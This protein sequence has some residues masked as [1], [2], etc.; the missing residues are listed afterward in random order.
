MERLLS[1]VFDILAAGGVCAQLQDHDRVRLGAE[2]LGSEDIQEIA[3]LVAEFAPAYATFGEGV[4][5]PQD[6]AAGSTNLPPIRQIVVG[7][8]SR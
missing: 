3:D 6:G 4:S 2:G 7:T 8:R 1:A 5:R